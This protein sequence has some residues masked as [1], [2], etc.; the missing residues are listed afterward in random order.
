MHGT[1]GNTR[2]E[3]PGPVRPVLAASGTGSRGGVL[4]R[5][6]PI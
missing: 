6:G 2:Q 4:P 1:R 3:E 5:R